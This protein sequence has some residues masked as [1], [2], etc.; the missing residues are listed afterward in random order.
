MR[1]R[2]RTVAWGARDMPYRHTVIALTTRRPRK[3]KGI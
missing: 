1:S 3:E 2:L